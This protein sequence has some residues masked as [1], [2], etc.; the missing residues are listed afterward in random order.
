M[1]IYTNADGNTINYDNIYHRHDYKRRPVKVKVMYRFRDMFSSHIL[2]AFINH[3]QW[4]L[5]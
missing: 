5:L 4:R 1:T 3:V 2:F